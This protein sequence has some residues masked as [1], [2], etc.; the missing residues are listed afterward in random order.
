MNATASS[1]AV[2]SSAPNNVA[3]TIT[4]INTPPETRISIFPA[5]GKVAKR[6]IYDP[7]IDAKLDKKMR[8]KQVQYKTVVDK[9]CEGYT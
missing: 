4:P 5:D 7:Y 3:D 8:S 6:L 1:R 9:V 2:P